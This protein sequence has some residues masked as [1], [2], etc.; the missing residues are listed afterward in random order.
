MRQA[1]PI[2]AGSMWSLQAKKCVCFNSKG[3][4]KLK[5]FLTGTYD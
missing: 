2:R 4:K 5:G 3:N 1:G